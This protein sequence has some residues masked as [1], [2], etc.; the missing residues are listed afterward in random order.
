MAQND[1]GTWIILLALAGL[2]GYY[3][4][5]RY[6]IVDTEEEPIEVSLPPVP[7]PAATLPDMM[8]ATTTS[9]GS[10]WSVDGTAIR[11]PRTARLAWLVKDHS[12]DETVTHRETKTLYEMNCDRGSYIVRSL[13]EYDAEGNPSGSWGD[14]AFE[15]TPSYMAPG[16][17]MASVFM[18][19]CSTQVD[20]YL[21]QE[22]TDTKAGS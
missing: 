17:Q 8:Y 10:K 11:G 16:T 12:E 5:Q 6:D 21:Q 2:G 3:L 4:W 20:D 19:A 15:D 7:A 1:D 18:R 14:E 22:M 9:S 13:I